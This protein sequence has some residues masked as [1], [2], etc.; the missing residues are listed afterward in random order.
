[1]R[2]AATSGCRSTT[3][4]AGPGASTSC[5]TG[6]CRKKSSR[7][8]ARARASTS[9]TSR[10]RFMPL[11]NRSNDW[12]IDRAGAEG[13]EAR[14][15]ASKA[16]RSRMHRCRKAW[17]RSRTTRASTWSRP[18]SRSSMT[19]RV[20]YN[21]ARNLADGIEPPALDAASQRVRAAGGAARAS[22]PASRVGD[23]RALDGLEPTGVHPE[24]TLCFFF[25]LA[26]FA[27]PCAAQEWT[28]R[29]PVRIIVPM[30]GRHR[31]PAGAARGAAICR[32]P[33][34]SPSSSKTRRARAAT[35]ARTRSRRP[36]PT[37]HMLCGYNG[38]ITVNPTLFGNLPYDPAE[39]PRADH[40]CGH[41]A[42]VPDRPPERAVHIGRGA[43]RAREGAARQAQLRRRS[44]SAAL[45]T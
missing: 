17:G 30:P 35:S 14:S 24:E 45:R 1:M 25:L 42:A 21:A 10:A 39:R 8:C 28:P 40:A 22:D 37:G 36:I 15:A 12:L 32:R 43:D 5:P 7:R 27:A 33:S 31:R 4:T 20:L 26:T 38:P 19:R 18:T 11:A 29:K 9:S 3:R 2:S 6:R 34:A 41:R 16:S 13:Q 44:R 23:D